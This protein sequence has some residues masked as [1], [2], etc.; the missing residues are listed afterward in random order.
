LQVIGLAALGGVLPDLE[1][2]LHHGL[3]RFGVSSGRGIFP[4]HSGVLPHRNLRLPWGFAIQL[5]V[6]G[7]C[8]ASLALFY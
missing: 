7:L 8:L 1:V 5:V 4:S 3:E 6:G 2:V